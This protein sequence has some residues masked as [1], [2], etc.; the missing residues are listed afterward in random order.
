MVTVFGQYGSA[1]ATLFCARFL[2]NGQ[3]KAS[4]E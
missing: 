1:L 3:I 4:I 2:L